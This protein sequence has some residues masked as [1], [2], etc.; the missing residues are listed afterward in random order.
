M[1]NIKIEL[2]SYFAEIKERIEIEMNC[3]LN[4]IEV[5]FESNKT[6][7][8]ITGVKSRE[9]EKQYKKD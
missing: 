9:V 6:T 7:L 1:E 2:D 4:K 5:D 8:V 3:A